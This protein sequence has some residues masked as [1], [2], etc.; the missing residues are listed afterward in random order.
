MAKK[1]H[2]E[3]DYF[4]ELNPKGTIMSVLLNSSQSIIHN[5]Y[6]YYLWTLSLSGT[7]STGL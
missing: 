7:V 1:N 6:S 2:V 4:Q 5:V 3:C